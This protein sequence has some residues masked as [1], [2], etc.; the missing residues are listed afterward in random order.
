[1][2]KKTD[3]RHR[4][5]QHLIKQLFAHSYHPIEEPEVE[6]TQII[7]KIEFVDDTI[8]RNAPEWPID[9]INK[10][11]LAVLRLAIYELNFTKTPH[12][13]VVD[14][15]VELGK[16]YGSNTSAKFINGV[17]GS[18]LKKDKNQ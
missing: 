7:N 17:L 1:M 11:D 3:P 8:S 5:R 4:H 9:Q 15:A 18:H 6:V 13:V 14:E 16:E 12:K 10:I 2:K